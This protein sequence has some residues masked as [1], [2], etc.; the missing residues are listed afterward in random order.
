MPDVKRLIAKAQERATECGTPFVV[1]EHDKGDE[2]GFSIWP[3]DE[4]DGDE[5]N[6]FDAEIIAEVYPREKYDVL[7]DSKLSAYWACPGCD[8]STEWPVWEYQDSGTPM[9]IKCDRD[10]EYI[11][12]RQYQ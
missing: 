8:E 9:C 3:M 12:T 4:V 1:A 2:R 6:A 7:D 11:E 5:W 10:M